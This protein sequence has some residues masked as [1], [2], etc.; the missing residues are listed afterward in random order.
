MP[1]GVE[2]LPTLL[3][4]GPNLVG[5]RLTLKPEQGTKLTL[6]QKRPKTAHG[7]TL[8]KNYKQ[9]DHRFEMFSVED[10]DAA[11]IDTPF[12]A[13]NSAKHVTAELRSTASAAPG[14]VQAL[15]RQRGNGL[16]PLS[17]S[18]CCSSYISHERENAKYG[19]VIAARP[20]TSM[21]LLIVQP[22]PPRLLAP[23]RDNRKDEPYPVS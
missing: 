22:P 6:S 7:Q 21:R 1:Q 8:P 4:T 9:P 18:I 12:A 2:D 13:M 15:E 3:S 11:E 14:L 16:R 17:L 23:T 5:I 19:G 20:R 10:D